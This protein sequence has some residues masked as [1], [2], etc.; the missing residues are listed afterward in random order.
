MAD[1]G[2]TAPQAGSSRLP[3]MANYRLQYKIS[4][5][6]TG[7]HT[8]LATRPHYLKYFKRSIDNPLHR[9]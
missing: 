6:Q 4:H 9:A 8:G 5:C 1:E 7:A 2:I 3:G